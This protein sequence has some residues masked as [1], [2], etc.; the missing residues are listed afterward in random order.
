MSKEK[1]KQAE[2]QL[3]KLWQNKVNQTCKELTGKSFTPEDKKTFEELS[4]SIAV[5]LLDGDGL[6]IRSYQN[7]L[8]LF[9]DKEAIEATETI[10]ENVTDFCKKALPIVKVMLLTLL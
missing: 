8:K 9:L 6:L 1:L 10:T 4:K 2:K 5:A 7:D 3:S